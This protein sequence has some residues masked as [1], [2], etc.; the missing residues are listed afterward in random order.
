MFLE[1]F[2]PYFLGFEKYIILKPFWTRV[3]L[4]LGP[5]AARAEPQ[6]F[7]S[8]VSKASMGPKVPHEFRGRV[9]AIIPLLSVSF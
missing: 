9:A 7:G 6:G 1:A 3:G 8:W 5:K 2:F 4:G